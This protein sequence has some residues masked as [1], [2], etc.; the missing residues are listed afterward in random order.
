MPTQDK[1]IILL[2]KMEADK[3]ELLSNA[4]QIEI[5]GFYLN[6]FTYLI[7]RYR[8]RKYRLLNYS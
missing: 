7:N 8:L 1:S 6:K 2:A 5:T 3:T 4:N